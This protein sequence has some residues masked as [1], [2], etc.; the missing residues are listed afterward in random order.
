MN[1]IAFSKCIVALGVLLLLGIPKIVE[2]QVTIPKIF[3]SNMVLQQNS[4]VNIWG[5]ATAGEKVSIAGSWNG[6]RVK[7]TTGSD[8][9]WSIK[10]KTP[11]ANSESIRYTLTIEG[12]NKI[13]LDNVLTGEVWLLSGQS[14][15]EL[16]MKGWSVPIA[17]GKEAIESANYP[18]IR[19]IVAG[20]MSASTPQTDIAKN[21]G[22]FTW[23]EC[24]PATVKDFSALGYFFAKELHLD[25]KVPIGLVVSAWGGSS[26]EAWTKSSSL[27]KVND[28]K[29]KGPWISK[30]GDDNQT[31]T[32]LYNGMIAPIVS[33]T[34]AGALWYQGETNVGRAEQLTQLFP[35]MI[36]GWRESWNSDKFPFY[37]VQLCPWGGNGGYSL[38]E[39]WEAQ[40][41][42]LSLNNTG[43]AATLDVGD[44]KDIHPVRKEPVGHRLALIAKAN[45][46]GSAKLEY[47][48]PQY[49]S[50]T[51]EGNTI[52]LRFDHCGSGLK[53]LNGTLNQFEV[54]GD[55]KAYVEAEAMIE[56]NDV[57]VRN[58]TI[59]APKHVRYAWSGTAT[60]SLYNQEDLPAPPFRTDKPV[61]LQPIIK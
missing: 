31:P 33:F 20:H 6:K 39:A 14:N 53:A 41:S 61:Y 35:A 34:F 13:T 4:E 55:D 21:W 16:P 54:A 42:A 40:A 48:G 1:K 58:K 11:K 29:D 49:K 57:I 25:L 51:I 15:M 38:P 22:N 5:R 32:C 27:Q 7:T 30:N 37:F 8:G 56:G 2:A 45:Q 50:M 17:G 12:T 18:N 23:T 52:R 19:F 3:A 28:Y 46:Y 59:S 60:A 9:K 36:K 24:N 43:M 26:C 44:V 10:L 47:S